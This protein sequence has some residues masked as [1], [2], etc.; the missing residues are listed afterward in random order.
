M[1]G[2]STPELSSGTAPSV[3]NV[4]ARQFTAL[5]AEHAF[6]ERDIVPLRAREDR[7]NGIVPGNGEACKYGLKLFASRLVKH[8]DTNVR[9]CSLDVL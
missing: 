6:L 2:R 5:R 9:D 7:Q 4:S 8:V 1:P 3:R